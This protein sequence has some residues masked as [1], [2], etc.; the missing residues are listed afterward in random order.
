MSD[1]IRPDLKVGGVNEAWSVFRHRVLVKKVFISFH[2][3]PA[4][5]GKMFSIRKK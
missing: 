4:L 2:G 3:L 5:Y 1:F